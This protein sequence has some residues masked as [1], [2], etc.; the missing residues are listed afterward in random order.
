MFALHMSMEV[1]PAQAGN[2]TVFIGTVVPQEKHG[3]LEDL[4]LLILDPEVV[5]CP[6]K[7]LLLKLFVSFRSIIGENHKIGLGLRIEQS[8]FGDGTVED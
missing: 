4:I 8:A 2:I 1:Q 3:V 7:V 5:V 6:G